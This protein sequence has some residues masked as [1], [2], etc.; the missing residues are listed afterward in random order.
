[1]HEALKAAE[2]AVQIRERLAK[3]N[4]DGFGLDLAYS[5][6]NLGGVYWWLGDLNKAQWA[7]ERAL[8]VLDRLAKRNPD[9][10]EPGLAAVL[11]ALGAIRCEAN[12]RQ[13]VCA[14]RRGVETLRRLF[15]LQPNVYARQMAELQQGY[16]QSCKL[17]AQEPD[18]DLLAPIAG[19][20]QSTPRPSCSPDPGCE[21]C[22][23]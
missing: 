5:L 6:D 20:M 12:P 13:A 21:V 1:L 23:T 9:A 16:L 10:F 11:R 18:V 8:E 7:A 17:S 14:F 22:A 4:P 2:R 3:Q 19:A 15:L